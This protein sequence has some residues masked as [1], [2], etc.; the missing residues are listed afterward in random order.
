MRCLRPGSVAFALAM[1]LAAARPAGAEITA[2]L[3]SA[4]TPSHRPVT[5]L[6]FGMTLVAVG[7]EFEYASAVERTSDAAPGLRTGMVNGV[8]QTPIA[9]GG[10]RFYGTAGIGAYRETTA[11]DAVNGVGMNIGGGVKANL[12]GPLRLR[13]D[14]RLLKLQGSARHPRVHRLYA[15]L[16]LSF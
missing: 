15:G 1:L 5:G 2:F 16:A 4:L 14:Y 6:A 10:L 8:V 11:G 12:V 13:F 9:V 3:G 7:V